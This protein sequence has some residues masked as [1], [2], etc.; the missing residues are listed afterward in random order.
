MIKLGKRQRYWMKKMHEDENI[1]TPAS[2]VRKSMFN[3]RQPRG[4][5]KQVKKVKE[6]KV[7]MQV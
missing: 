1:T 5:E 4:S 7:Q 6:N 3:T 2:V